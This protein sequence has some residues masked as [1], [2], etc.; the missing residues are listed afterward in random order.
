MLIYAHRA[1]RIETPIPD[2]F[3]YVNAISLK[4]DGKVGVGRIRSPFGTKLFA[5]IEAR[6]AQS[7]TAPPFWADLKFQFDGVTL[8]AEI[9]NSVVIT[10]PRSILNFDLESDVAITLEKR[11]NRYVVP[12]FTTYADTTLKL[13][14]E[15]LLVALKIFKASP[16]FIIR[17]AN[18]PEIDELLELATLLG[19]A[20]FTNPGVQAIRSA[21]VYFIQVINRS[22]GSDSKINHSWREMIPDQLAYEV[23]RKKFQSSWIKTI[24]KALPAQLRK[25][26]PWMARYFPLPF[27]SLAEVMG[28]L[29][30]KHL[31]PSDAKFVA[32][33]VGRKVWAFTSFEGEKDAEKERMVRVKHAVAFMQFMFR[34]REVELL[35]NPDFN[36]QMSYIYGRNFSA[37]DLIQMLYG[38]AEE[39]AFAIK[40]YYRHFLTDLSVEQV[41]DKV[42]KYLLSTLK[43]PDENGEKWDLDSYFVAMSS[44]MSESEKLRIAQTY[45]IKMKALEK[46]MEDIGRVKEMVLI[47]PG[48]ELDPQGTFLT[49]TAKRCLPHIVVLAD[50]LD[51]IMK[52]PFK[53]ATLN[54]IT[55]INAAIYSWL[56][57]EACEGL[58]TTMMQ[59]RLD[60]GTLFGAAEDLAKLY[61]SDK[62]KFEDM[63]KRLRLI[64]SVF[65]AFALPEV[66]ADDQR[67][68]AAAFTDLIDSLPS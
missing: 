52:D 23:H 27:I 9:P 22:N 24:R 63:V 34:E 42:W 57:G 55:S 44:D 54:E 4:T 2:I 31:H 29:M 30:R 33:Q 51:K 68:I 21:Y 14:R 1:H 64:Q 66:S 40:F 37:N 56:H 43:L 20:I 18:C 25:L 48:L 46:E 17:P 10:L 13:L 32:D 67:K 62:A 53:G 45:G 65:F 5:G 50:P 60:D 6:F 12:N 15:K 28:Y 38:R 11:I 19:Q 35:R 47:D 36:E 58:G 16:D 49:E 61:E 8:P 26:A 59:F 3:T 41:E 7:E 39:K